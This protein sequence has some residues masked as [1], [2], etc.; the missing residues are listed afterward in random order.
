MRSMA[1]PATTP[2]REEPATI[3]EVDSTGDKV[4]EGL[5]AG[6]DR[7]DS[8]I[9]WTLGANIEDLVLYGFGNL[10]GTGNAL[11]NV[12]NGNS[13]NNLLH[14]LGGNDHLLGYAGT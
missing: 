14:G 8:Y 7:V 10:N 2:L 13:G 6:T 4:I 1:A 12:F 9:S 3:Y 5:N 11:A